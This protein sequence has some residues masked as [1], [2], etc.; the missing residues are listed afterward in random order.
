LSFTALLANADAA[1]FNLLRTGRFISSDNIDRKLDHAWPTRHDHHLRLDMTDQRVRAGLD[2]HHTFDTPVALVTLRPRDGV[3]SP[4]I[5]GKLTRRYAG[6][7]G[8]RQETGRPD[9]G[10]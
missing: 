6:E 8:C 1:T 9:T 4:S 7:A 2:R 10:A 5:V 3:S